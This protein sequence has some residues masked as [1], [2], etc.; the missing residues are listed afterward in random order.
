M[1]F[2]LDIQIAG[3]LDLINQIADD[4]RCRE[5]KLAAEE[6]LLRQSSQDER[7]WLF[8]R[9]MEMR[10]FAEY[11]SERD[12]CDI[13]VVLLRILIRLDH[14]AKNGHI[15]IEP[16]LANKSTPNLID[17]LRALMD[18]EVDTAFEDD[19]KFAHKLM[20]LRHRLEHNEGL[21]AS[22]SIGGFKCW[23]DEFPYP[24]DEVVAWAI[25]LLEKLKLKLQRRPGQ[26]QK[27]SE[28]RALLAGKK[29]VQDSK[30]GTDAP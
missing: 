14:Y 20:R 23:P 18:P 29:K 4:R 26:Q 7:E 17:V 9:F 1:D 21:Y 12:F 6:C 30:R 5:E 10:E 13:Y 8:E 27:T 2:F 19:L 16:V 22:G 24:F 11:R 15:G 3:S 25:H 28:L